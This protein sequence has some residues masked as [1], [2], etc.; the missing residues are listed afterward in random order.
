MAI[1]RD[2]SCVQDRGINF[3]RVNL[4]KR[5]GCFREEAPASLSAGIAAAAIAGTANRGHI[6]ATHVMNVQLPDGSVAHIQY[7][8]DVAPKVTVEPLAPSRAYGCRLDRW[9]CRSFAGFDQDGAQM[10]RQVS[11]DAANG[12][13]RDR[14]AAPGMNVAVAAGNSTGRVTEHQRGFRTA[15]AAQQLHADDRGRLAGST[16]KPLEVTTNV[17]SMR[18][19]RRAAAARGRTLDRT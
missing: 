16:G 5:G 11:A 15:T 3:E 2:Q 13:A 4:E 1:V 19:R 6:P 18:L 10:N 9:R 7:V 8:G 17:R 14:S 12:A